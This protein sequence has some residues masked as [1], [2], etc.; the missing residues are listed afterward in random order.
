MDV[1]DCRPGFSNISHGKCVPFFPLPVLITP[2]S[3][4]YKGGYSVDVTLESETNSKTVFCRFGN[5]IVAGF[6]KD[7]STIR[8]LA[9]EGAIGGIELRVSS[10]ANDWNLPGIGFQ[11]VMGTF[12]RI[13][14]YVL[15]GFALFAVIAVVRLTVSA[16]RNPQPE[17]LAE[18]LQPLKQGIPRAN[19]G[20]ADLS[21]HGF[22][23]L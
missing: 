15:H 23:P 21:M 13:G 5:V 22:F 6:L 18:E 20:H 16:L 19:E 10:D 4:S 12:D 1:C 14:T 3:G 7:Q 11:Y 9:P 8:C 2:L 17:E